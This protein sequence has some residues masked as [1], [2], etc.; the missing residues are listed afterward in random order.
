MVMHSKLR[1]WL[2]I[3]GIVIGVAAVIAIVSLGQ[4]LQQTMNTQFDALGGDLLTLR[5]GASQ[6]YGFGGGRPD[7]SGST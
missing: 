1:S 7:G 6:A 4:T 5:A 2:T 3:L